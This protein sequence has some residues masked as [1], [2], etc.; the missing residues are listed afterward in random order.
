MTKS[1]N[2]IDNQQVQN[3]CSIENLAKMAGL[4]AQTIRHYI[5]GRRGL[6]DKNHEKINGVFETIY[7]EVKE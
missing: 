2:F 6:D 4:H 3:L 5:K 7:K 1:N